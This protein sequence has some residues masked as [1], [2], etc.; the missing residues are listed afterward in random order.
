MMIHHGQQVL[1]SLG[2]SLSLSM[3][4][5]SDEDESEDVSVSVPAE[6]ITVS[7]PAPTVTATFSADNIRERLEGEEPEYALAL[8]LTSTRLEQVMSYGIRNHLDIAKDQ[9][10]TL[11]GNESLGTLG[12]LCSKLDVYEDEFEQEV[13]DDVAHQRRN[14][15]HDT[16]EHGYNYLQT[17]EEDKDVQQEVEDAVEKALRFIETVGL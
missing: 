13:I 6:K 4:E 10:E 12:Q 5:E 1:F 7:E 11:L 3:T 9:Y 16:P 14:L 2:G 15:V 8:I 17:L